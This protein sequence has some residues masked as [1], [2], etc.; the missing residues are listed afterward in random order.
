MFNIFKKK[1]SEPTIEENKHKKAFETPSN[2]DH[3]YIYGFING[4][5][6]QTIS[7]TNAVKEIVQ[8][9]AGNKGFVAIDSIFHPYNLVNHKGATA[10]DLAWFKVAFH[11]NGKFIGEIARDKS[12]T[13]IKSEELNLKDNYRVWPNNDLDP[14]RNPHYAKYVPFVFPYLTY[15][16]KDEPHWSRM[17][18]S[19]LKDYGHAHT[20][21]EYFNSIFS[22]YVSGHIM[23]LGFGEFDRENLD[24]LI[25]KFTSFYDRN[26]KN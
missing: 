22:K 9:T 21:I 1:K 3:N 7:D 26:I 25:E 8:N 17:I 18:N 16:S 10:W 5:P 11:D 24:G 15:Q 13:V 19:E 2:W 12:A 14:E 23:T 6:Q 4:N 20:Y